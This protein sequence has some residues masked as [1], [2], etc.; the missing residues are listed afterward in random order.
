M[1]AEQ[2]TSVSTTK[3]VT[4]KPWIVALAALLFY[5]LSLNH[6]VTLRSMPWIAPV[7]GWDW[8]SIPIQWRPSYFAPLW[9]VVTAPFRILPVAWQPL[10][11]NFFAAV[12]AALTLALLTHSVRLFPH[13]RTRDQRIRETGEFGLFSGRWAWVPQLS[14]VLALAFAGPFW[15]NAICASNEMLD[16]L[17]FA[18]IIYCLMRFRIAQDERWLNAMAFVYGLG[19]TNN[20]ALIGFFP[21]FLFALIWIKGLGFFTGRFFWLTFFW[22]TAGLLLYLLI[23]LLGALSADHQNFGELLLNELKQQSFIL[24]RI[25][26]WIAVVAGLS[27]VAPLICAGFRWP[28]IEGEISA[29]G[30]F[31][32]RLTFTSMNV[33]FLPVALL[34]FFD[35]HFSTN[36]QVHEAPTPYLTFYYLAALSVGYYS[37]Y[38][39][40]V[41]GKRSLQRIKFKSSPLLNAS[42]IAMVWILMIAAPAWLLW[43]NFG[44]LRFA[45]NGVLPRFTDQTIAALPDR[46]AIILSDDPIRLQLLEAGYQRSGKTNPHILLETGALTYREYYRY[47]IRRYPQLQKRML[48]PEKIPDILSSANVGDFVYQLGREYPIYYLHPSFGFFFEQYYVKP[49]RVAYELKSYADNSFLPPLV[50][51]EEIAENQQFWSSI[52]ESTLDPLPRLAHEDWDAA[53]VSLDYSVAL[54]FW[55]VE[56]QKANHLPEA[57]AAFAEAYAVN[58]NNFLAKYNMAYNERLQRGDHSPVGDSDIV[59]SAMNLYRTVPNIIKY[60]GPPDEPD[61]DL[62]FGESLAQGGNLRQA[63]GLF[64]RRLQL[65]P[66]DVPA[67]MAVAKTLVDIG[68]IDPGLELIHQ[69]RSQTNSL[70]DELFWVEAVAYLSKT[71]YSE[72]ERSLLQGLQQQPNNPSRLANTLEFYRRTGLSALRQGNRELGIARLKKALD[73]ANSFEQLLAGNK[74][75]VTH[76]TIAD[77]LMIK[78]DIEVSLESWDDAA[79]TL[80]RVIDTD[81]GNADALLNHAIVL[82]HLKQYDAAKDDAAA[83]K[84]A[85]PNEPYVAYS[86]FVDIARAEKDAEAEKKYLRLYLKTAPAAAPQY[87]AMKQELARIEAR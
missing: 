19:V 5:C 71:N 50:T 45:N 86:Q 58:T 48:S 81:Y 9:L 67:K 61:V 23:P 35:W 4:I 6:W 53:S 12:C 11:L 25:P 84:K 78:A 85:L 73:Y 54:D 31:L 80:G 42:A 10:A 18:F 29:A 16:L 68:R 43:T 52:K 24:R 55:G 75:I 22:G 51:P 49:H 79:K 17:V 36:P 41:F 76:Y 72:A 33:L 65:L 7:T 44:R 27:S 1:T 59:L 57:H 15:D 64:Q 14:A 83:L 77:V 46:P 20:F 28:E 30:N 70:P 74:E 38:I 82:T 69:I 62:V 34:I 32:T 40:I 39:L 26:G 63:G 8:H 37:G 56:L 21:L 47:L 60:N 13:D 3:S 87:P 66:N 2:P